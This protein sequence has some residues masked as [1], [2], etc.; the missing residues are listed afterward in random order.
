MAIW[1]AQPNT[2]SLTWHE[3][4]HDAARWLSCSC[5]AGTTCRAQCQPEA[6]TLDLKKGGR[7]C[8]TGAYLMPPLH[9][10]AGKVPS[11]AGVRRHREPPLLQPARQGQRALE[12]DRSTMARSP[13]RGMHSLARG[14]AVAPPP[15]RSP[16]APL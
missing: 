6:L 9:R 14:P 11:A 10:Y 3:H 8:L 5:R 15:S 2:G 16:W 7:R 4:E 12:K 1:P 13:S